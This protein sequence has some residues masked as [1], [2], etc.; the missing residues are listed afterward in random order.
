MKYPS[1]FSGCLS[2]QYDAATSQYKIAGI[3]ERDTHSQPFKNKGHIR[4]L[5]EVNY[6]SCTKLGATVKKGWALVF[7]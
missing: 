1:I 5:K 4:L 6:W 7:F 3:S 2:F